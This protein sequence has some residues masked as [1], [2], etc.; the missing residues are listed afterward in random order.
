MTAK[1]YRIYRNLHN[2]KLSIKDKKT[3]LVC[4]YS[5]CVIL[6]NVKFVVLPSGKR[7]T[8]ETGVRNVHAFVEGELVSAAR[9]EQYKGRAIE[10]TDG[11][12]WEIWEG[13]NLIGYKPFE[14]TGFF[15]VCSGREIT[16]CDRVCVRVTPEKSYIEA[17]F[18]I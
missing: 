11:N 7:R 10:T 4:G 9:F 3:G 16:E 13:K 8:I 6:D 12:P 5:D 1:R 14:E 17:R 2:G 18:A 15:F